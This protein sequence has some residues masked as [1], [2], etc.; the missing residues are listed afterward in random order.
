MLERTRDDALL[1][2][3]IDRPAARNALSRE[4][5][6]RLVDALDEA[7]NDETVGGVV[8]ASSHPS[9]FIAGGDL[10][11]LAALP[12]TPQGAERVLE[13]GAL[14]RAI[15]ACAVP[16]LAAVSGAALGGGAEVTVACDLVV[17]SPASYIRF[18]HARMGLVPAWGGATRLEERVGALRAN[19]LLLSARPVAAPEAYGLGLCNRIAEDARGGALSL[20]R[21]LAAST[22]GATAALK[23]SATAARSA[24]RGGAIAAEQE[25][26]RC[27]WGS[28][29][30][31]M[32]FE[33]IRTKQRVTDS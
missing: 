26:F 11:E 31:R 12:M 28:P 13:L 19:E 9:V 17:M 7:S 29:A 4:L 14:T 15:E 18:V 21:E 27:A 22:R 2:L 6:A 24:R 25:A 20:A 16:V 5:V 1:V 30:H 33:A 32:A 8:L 3:T 10:T 23:R